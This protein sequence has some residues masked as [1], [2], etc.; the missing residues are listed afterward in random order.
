MAKSQENDSTIPS[1]LEGYEAGKVVGE[2]MGIVVEI[3]T[4]LKKPNC[5]CCNSV[6]LHRHGRVRKGRLL[7]GWS[8][9]EKVHIEIARHRWR[10]HGCR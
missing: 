10:C 5:S 6:K 3:G 1:G 9:D 2:E 4:E 8:R 7:H